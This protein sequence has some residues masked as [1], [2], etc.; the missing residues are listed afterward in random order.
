MILTNQ[1]CIF[2][3]ITS[4]FVSFKAKYIATSDAKHYP[5][6]T[7]LGTTSLIFIK[8]NVTFFKDEKPVQSKT[9]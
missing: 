1:S 6:Y 4:K 5:K 9:D 8:R 3:S 2:F 7:E